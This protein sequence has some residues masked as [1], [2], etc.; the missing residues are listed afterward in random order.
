[1]YYE[2]ETEI[3]ERRD[4]KTSLHNPAELPTT[5]TSPVDMSRAV[6]NFLRLRA[7]AAFVKGKIAKAAS[8]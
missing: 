5:V 7:E 4:A 8:G 6:E 1:M 3:R 2:T